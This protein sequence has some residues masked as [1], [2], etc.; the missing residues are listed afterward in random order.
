MEEEKSR[1]NNLAQSNAAQAQALGTARSDIAD[2][3]ETIADLKNLIDNLRRESFEKDRIIADVTQNRDILADIAREKD[4]IIEQKDAVI[5][6]QQQNIDESHMKFDEY[7]RELKESRDSVVRHEHTIRELRS[8]SQERE[9]EL[10]CKQKDDATDVDMKDFEE[11]SYLRAELQRRD[12][13][14]A[15]M[16][17]AEYARELKTDRIAVESAQREDA[18]RSELHARSAEISALSSRGEE[19][20]RADRE[21]MNEVLKELEKTKAAY[22]RAEGE[23]LT[24]AQTLAAGPKQTEPDLE[25]NKPPAQ[26]RGRSRGSRWNPASWFRMSSRSTD[27]R[28]EDTQAAG[29]GGN[30]QGAVVICSVCDDLAAENHCSKCEL[31]CCDMC[32]LKCRRCG[33]LMCGNGM[34]AQQQPLNSRVRKQPGRSQLVRYSDGTEKEETL[35]CIFE[36]EFWS[37]PKLTAPKQNDTQDESSK[38]KQIPEVS[39]SKQKDESDSFGTPN[40]RLGGDEGAQGV[41]DP[42]MPQFLRTPKPRVC[43]AFDGCPEG[44]CPHQPNGGRNPQGI[45]PRFLC[46]LWPLFSQA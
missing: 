9:Q 41:P 13:A 32:Y 39:P 16:R 35:G 1:A 33:S 42:P 30:P 4:A 26:D 5:G 6:G 15:Q 19:T 44:Q 7:A 21:Q 2:K 17:A 18:L 10:L 46:F 43:V 34:I 25:A 8:Q 12:A 37:C 29:E 27:G 28:L 36:H 3:S 20:S 45:I 11:L 40:S 38:Q 24:L 22:H 31:P 23:R 14:M